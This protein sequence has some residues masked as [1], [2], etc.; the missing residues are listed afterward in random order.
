MQ[1]GSSPYV[2][3]LN[4]DVIVTPYWLKK[5]IA[6]AESDESIATVNPLTNFAS[7]IN[8]KIAPGANYLGMNEY[9]EK[10]TKR[11]YPDIITCVGF[12]LLIRRSALDDVGIFDEIYGAGYCEESD[13]GMRLVTSGYRTVIADD[14]YVYHKGR[15]SFVSRGERFKRNYKIFLNR[16]GKRY[17][18]L[19]REFLVR[20]PLSYIRNLF[21]TKRAFHPRNFIW[22]NGKAVIA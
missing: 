19:F 6:C 21:E 12:C 17:K 9:I 4:S 16:W 2:L 8:I 10:N 5:L 20:D 15:A 11:M 1:A 7:N 14:T 18:R 3:L 13:L 22:V